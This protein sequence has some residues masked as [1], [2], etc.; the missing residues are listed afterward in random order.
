MS[1]SKEYQ[2]QRSRRHSFWNAT[3]KLVLKKMLLVLEDLQQ[4]KV[5]FIAI[6]EPKFSQGV[7]CMKQKTFNIQ[8]KRDTTTA[9]TKSGYVVNEFR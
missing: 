5:Q 6:D 7:L 8:F 2:Q 3:L 9:S 1:N 4:T